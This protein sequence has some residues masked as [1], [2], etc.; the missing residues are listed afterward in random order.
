VISDRRS[1]LRKAFVVTLRPDALEQYVYWHENIWPEL[2]AQFALSGI[3]TVSVFENHPQVYVY[4]EISDDAAWA[5]HFDADVCQRWMSTVMQPL[6][7]LDRDG[8]QKALDLTQ[9]WHLPAV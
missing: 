9:I 2:A 4:S 1:L 7:E 5:R 6:M 8:S 3:M